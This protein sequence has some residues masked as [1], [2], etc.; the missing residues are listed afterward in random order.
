MIDLQMGNELV[1]VEYHNSEVSMFDG[2][3]P[4]SGLAGWSEVAGINS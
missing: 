2:S 4:D 3:N 1:P